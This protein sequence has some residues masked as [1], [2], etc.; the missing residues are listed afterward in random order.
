MCVWTFNPKLIE[1]F[2]ETSR[3][4]KHGTHSISP[5]YHYSAADSAHNS[6]ISGTYNQC[7]H[8]FGV[9]L[10]VECATAASYVAHMQRK[11][12][13][14]SSK[15][16]DDNRRSESCRWSCWSCAEQKVAIIS[17]HVRIVRVCGR[18][19]TW[20]CIE[21]RSSRCAAVRRFVSTM[22][23]VVPIDGTIWDSVNEHGF[24]LD[25]T[26]EYAWS[27]DCRVVS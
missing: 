24:R 15:R 9:T 13:S 6:G 26:L 4:T 5:T 2:D 21:L 20:P 18:R 16:C 22:P 7:A 17:V 19:I 11:T 3:S 1:R 8:Q 25:G 23:M 12:T 14:S 27:F 10:L